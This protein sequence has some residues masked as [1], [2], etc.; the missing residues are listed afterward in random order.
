MGGG[1]GHYTLT[2][3]INWPTAV[4]L[5]ND[6]ENGGDSRN[7]AKNSKLRQTVFYSATVA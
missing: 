4:H 6:R 1:Q 5:K 3:S 2:D 7:D